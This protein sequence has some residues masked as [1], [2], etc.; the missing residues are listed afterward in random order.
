MPHFLDV[1]YR[2]AGFIYL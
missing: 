1:D 2:K